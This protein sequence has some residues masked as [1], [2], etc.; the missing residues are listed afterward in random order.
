MDQA[1]Q[2]ASRRRA[3]ERRGASD[4]DDLLEVLDAG[5]R[6]AAHGRRC[7]CARI[8]GTRAC[9][10][11]VGTTSWPAASRP[12]TAG[13]PPP[14]ANTRSNPRS[15]S[16]AARR[17]S[18]TTLTMPAPDHHVAHQLRR[19]GVD[20]VVALV[21]EPGSVF[22]RIGRQT[23]RCHGPSCVFGR[24]EVCQTAAARLAGP[25]RRRPHRA[26]RRV[27]RASPPASR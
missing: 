6:S 8:P 16:R 14:E 26:R 13:G 9:R 18:S 7:T 5:T 27:G 2:A 25:A 20:L 3:S 24:V 19:P 1:D 22:L 12:M 23:G 21:G 4:V 11:I 17:K 15:S 10:V